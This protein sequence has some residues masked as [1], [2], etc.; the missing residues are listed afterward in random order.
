VVID[1]K[2]ISDAFLLIEVLN[3][4]S[5]GPNLVLGPGATPSDGYFDVIMAQRG[6]RQEL[7]TYLQHRADGRD[8]ALTLPRQRAREVVIEGCAAL[9]IDDERVDTC[10]LGPITIDVVPAAITVLV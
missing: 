3:I 7:L 8:A 5:V 10:A 9:H 6:H 4:P 2:E 1:G